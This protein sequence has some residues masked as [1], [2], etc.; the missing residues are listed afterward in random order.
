MNCFKHY[1]SVGLII[2]GFFW[3]VL[4][5]LGSD[6]RDVLFGTVLYITPILIDVEPDRSAVCH[7]RPTRSVT[8]LDG[9]RE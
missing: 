6:H 8:K 2:D 4:K 5:L 7:C 9:P 1:L 3:S